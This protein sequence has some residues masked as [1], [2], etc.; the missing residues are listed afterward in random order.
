MVSQ[1]LQ[2]ASQ[3]DKT[4][5]INNI[6]LEAILKILSPPSGNG[7]EYDRKYALWA[8]EMGNVHQSNSI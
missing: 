3:Y 1:F 7:K 2:E 4:D 5:S 8:A 6:V